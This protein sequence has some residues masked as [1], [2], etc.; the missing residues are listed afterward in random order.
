MPPVPQSVAE[1]VPAGASPENSPL[2][3]FLWVLARSIPFWLI[4]SVTPLQLRPRS[5]GECTHDRL[6]TDGCIDS[7]VPGEQARGCD[8]VIEEVLRLQTNHGQGVVRPHSLP[9]AGRD[10]CGVWSDARAGVAA[11]SSFTSPG[12]AEKWSEKDVLG[13]LQQI[14]VMPGRGHA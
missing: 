1:D 9:D 2:R 3:F 6:P 8:R 11:S 13:F 12:R 10:G 14:G 5:P 7:R 4:G